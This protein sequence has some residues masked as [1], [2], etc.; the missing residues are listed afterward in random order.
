MAPT[1]NNIDFP[2]VCETEPALCAEASTGCAT[3]CAQCEMCNVRT[4]AAALKHY[5]SSADGT[6]K[7]DLRSTQCGL[8]Y[9]VCKPRLVKSPMTKMRVM[10]QIFQTWIH[11]PWSFLPREA[12][13]GVWG[14]RWKILRVRS[15]VESHPHYQRL[16]D[17]CSNLKTTHC[18]CFW[19]KT[20]IETRIDCCSETQFLPKDLLQLLFRRFARSR[21]N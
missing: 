17:K 11:L 18:N 6:A 16:K 5:S 19:W 9:Q 14:K 12:F 20:P 7:D 3:M 21:E 10:W 15:R 4:T 13:S 2:S 1:P 8:T